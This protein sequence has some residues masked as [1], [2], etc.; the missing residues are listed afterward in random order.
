MRR[1]DEEE[2]PAAQ[3]DGPL[4]DVGRQH[5][6]AQDRQARAQAVA[7]DAPER[8]AQGVLRRRE[9]DGRDLR[10]VAPLGDECEHQSLE[11]HLPRALAV[12][13]LQRRLHLLQL[14]A[15][16]G[17]LAARDHL[18]PLVQ[19]L[20]PEVDEER[21]GCPVGVL[22]R[23]HHGQDLADGGAQHRHYG[24]GPPRSGEDRPPGVAHGEQCCYEEG[25]VAE[26]GDDDHH[27]TV[28]A[29]LDG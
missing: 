4:R 23:Q 2:Q 24:Q 14:P 28:A 8:H 25:L 21:H 6:A 11:R 5:A 17:A 16:P 7:E 13:V 20:H 18:E 3:G 27:K 12:D 9:R 22:P 19:E 10:A 15:G 26:L 29:C 1:E